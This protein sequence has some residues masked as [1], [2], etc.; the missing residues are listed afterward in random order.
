MTTNL[1]KV[2]EKGK[3]W[4]NYQYITL[5]RSMNSIANE[6]NVYPIDVGDALN[7]FKIETRAMG[8]RV[9]KSEA[10]KVKQLLDDPDWLYEQYITNKI[11]IGRIAK[12]LGTYHGIVSDKLEQFDIR[13]KYHHTERTSY[14]SNIWLYEQYWIFNRTPHEISKIFHISEGI[15]RKWM[16][17]S[18]IPVRSI[19][20]RSKLR[21][22]DL[23]RK[24][25]HSI[26]WSGPGNPAW[27][28]G[29]T[30]EPY[31]IDFSNPIKRNIRTKFNNKCF[32][33]NSTINE[34]ENKQNLNVHHI[35]YNK[36]N[37]NADNYVVLCNKHH[38]KTNFNRWYWFNLLVN[39]WIYNNEIHFG[40][41][42][43]GVFI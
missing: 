27:K 28:G 25:K 7:Y 38:S 24:I 14:Y 3:Y 6:I 12:N 31:S 37:N 9:S 39:Y 1:E 19:S 15:I 26:R 41:L 21:E 33:C 16:H 42:N 18:G 13:K 32:I 10:L 20:E 40:E 5:H 35:D 30:R 11:P 34:N 43:K 17:E 23:D 36:K 22:K 4:L 8:G 29:K 2:I